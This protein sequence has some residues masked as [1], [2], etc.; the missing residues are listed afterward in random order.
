MRSKRETPSVT[1]ATLVTTPT[2]VQP[3]VVCPA[4]GQSGNACR[5]TVYTVAGRQL[6]P[7]KEHLIEQPYRDFV[8]ELQRLASERNTHIVLHREERRTYV[9]EQPSR[10]HAQTAS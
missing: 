7:G 2:T 10:S 8:D 4:Q 9:Y 3:F 1:A 6:L 5:V